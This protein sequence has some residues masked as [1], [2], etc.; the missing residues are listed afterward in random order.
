[1]SKKPSKLQQKLNYYLTLVVLVLLVV[2]PP[3]LCG[4]FYLSQ[5]P[6]VTWGGGDSPAYT[7][8]W[9][10]RERRPVGLG[11]ETRRMITTYSDTELCVQTKLRFLLWGTSPTAESATRQQRMVGVDQRWQPTGEACQ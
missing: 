5:V 11:L 2:L 10:H 8:L 7:R 9:V 4:L 3:L 6:D 1:M